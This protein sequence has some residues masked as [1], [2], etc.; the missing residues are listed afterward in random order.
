MR[1]TDIVRTEHV[2][3]LGGALQERGWKAHFQIPA[4]EG[5]DTVLSTGLCHSKANAIDFLLAQVARMVRNSQ[6]EPTLVY[7]NMQ[8]S[9][10]IYPHGSSWAYKVLE[11]GATGDGSALLGVDS[12]A[13][14]VRLA[15]RHLAQLVFAVDEAE[16]DGRGLCLLQGDEEGLAEFRGW[17]AWQRRH[18]A[19][20]IAGCSEVECRRRA[21]NNDDTAFVIPQGFHQGGAVSADRE[22]MDMGMGPGE[23][24]CTALVTDIV[25]NE[26]EMTVVVTLPQGRVTT[27][28]ATAWPSDPHAPLGSELTQWASSELITLIEDSEDRDLAVQLIKDVV[29]AAAKRAVE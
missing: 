14:A 4:E 3:R 20:E 7:G 22:D 1:L 28:S 23:M 16:G 6:Q 21:D 8:W 27:G 11:Y 2:R 9:M 18:H 12:P 26:V 17:V 24:S 19:A 29:L 25:G 10:L 13:D 5:A 15:R